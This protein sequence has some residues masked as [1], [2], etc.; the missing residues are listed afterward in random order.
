[1]FPKKFTKEPGK[2][3]RLGIHYTRA[4]LDG[5]DEIIHLGLLIAQSSVKNLP[6]LL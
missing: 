2:N 5:K 3:H 6:S 4:N 1:M